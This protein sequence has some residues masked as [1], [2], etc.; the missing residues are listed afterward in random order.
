MAQQHAII[1][2]VDVAAAIQSRTL[3]G[4]VYLF[5][6]MKFLG[7]TGEGTGD[8]VTVVPGAYWS[9]GSQAT[10]QVLNWLPYNLGSI[11]PTVPRSYVADRARATDRQALEQLSSV[12]EGFADPG[13]DTAAD[14]NRLQRRVG[15]QARRKRGGRSVTTS[16]VLDVTGNVVN[17]KSQA[18]NYPNP[19][20]TGITGQAVDEKIMYPAQYGSPDMVSDGWYWAASVDSARP[21]TYSYT[22]HVQLHEL[23]TRNDELVWESVDLTCGSALKITT[24]PKRNAF[25]GAGL[26]T[27]PMPIVA[28]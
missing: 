20:I 12:A 8:L 19:V 7:S 25:T 15:A 24:E 26:G 9:D 5:D 27:L 3:D 4:N 21:G 17:D 11:P 18:Y 2:L 23:V 14:L 13:V 6:N 28:P 22:M 1:V 16:K 10:E